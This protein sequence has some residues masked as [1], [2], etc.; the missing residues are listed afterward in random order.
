[1]GVFQLIFCCLFRRLRWFY[2]TGCSWLRDF[3][4]KN[5]KKNCRKKLIANINRGILSD[6]IC[7]KLSEMGH[8][9]LY[10]EC[11]HSMHDIFQFINNMKIFKCSMMIINF[12]EALQR[13]RFAIFAVCCLSDWWSKWLDFTTI[14][15]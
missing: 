7:I 3:A 11:T 12:A 8:L 9:P 1:M 6:G 5:E 13:D 10:I 4:R 2:S 14:P 15:S